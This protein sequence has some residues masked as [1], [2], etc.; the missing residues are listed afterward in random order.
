M[1]RARR[2]FRVRW[3]PVKRQRRRKVAGLVR[4]GDISWSSDPASGSAC[5]K[6]APPLEG[7]VDDT[8]VRVAVP[9]R[10]TALSDNV[11]GRLG[12]LH[13]GELALQFSFERR[14]NPSRAQGLIDRLS[15][16]SR[17]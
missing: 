16:M 3:R 15:E 10:L 2:C 1:G 13:P 17:R 9:D 6:Q 8:F 5:E 7:G 11:V 14:S 4:G 12:F